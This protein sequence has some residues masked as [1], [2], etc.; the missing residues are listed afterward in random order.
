MISFIKDMLE[1]I[2]DTKNPIDIALMSRRLNLGY[3]F[4]Q[5]Y[6]L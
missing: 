1:E 5:V 3:T 6:G 4:I 2:N